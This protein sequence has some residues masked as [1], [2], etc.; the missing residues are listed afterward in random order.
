MDAAV[1]TLP[2][3]RT[4]CGRCGTFCR[5]HDVLYSAA[6]DPVCA[7]CFELGELDLAKETY[8]R[9][10]RSGGYAA[11]FFAVVAIGATITFSVVAVLLTGIATLSAGGI[12]VAL[13]RDEDLRRKLG[14][15]LV[16]VCVS[17]AFAMLLAGGFSLLLILGAGFLVAAT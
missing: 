17:A 4:A 3:D 11:P 10:V 14:W 13:A 6:G 12:L 2:P 16:P 9:R 7:G 1:A 5:A 15:H 8:A